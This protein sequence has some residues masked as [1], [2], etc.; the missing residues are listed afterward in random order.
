MI[1]INRR[2]GW[3]AAA[4][5]SLTML[6][7]S[8]PAFAQEVSPDQLALARKYVD[9]TDKVDLFGTSLADVAGRTLQQVLKLNPALGG[10][11]TQA[12][13]DVVNDYKQHRGDLFDQIARVYAQHFTTDELQQLVTFYSSPVGQKLAGANFEINQ[14]LNKM[15]QLYQVNLATEFY[16]KVRANLK[17]KG[18]T[19]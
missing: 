15:M 12:V 13:T 17:A 1:R 7:A 19:L 6:A 14:Q 8:A 2:S 3:L 18:V 4:A 11:A 10:Q 9:L 5:L 16:A